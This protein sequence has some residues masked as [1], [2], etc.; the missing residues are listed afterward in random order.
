MIVFENTE[1]GSV[2]TVQSVFG[3]EP[4]ESVSVLG[5]TKNGTLRQFVFQT[6]MLEIISFSMNTGG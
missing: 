6:Q 2:I 4:H 5:D 1:I 3:A